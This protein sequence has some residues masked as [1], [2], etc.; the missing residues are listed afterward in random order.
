MKKLF[1][2]AFIIFASCTGNHTLDG[3]YVKG[4]GANNMSNE[5]L[6]VNGNEMT[7]AKYSYGGKLQGET[8]VTCTQFPDRI[9]FTENGIIKIMRIIDSGSLKLSDEAI[10]VRYG[11]F[12]DSFTIKEIKPNH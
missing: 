5:V 10:F 8:K 6:K 1:F 12:D 4:L 9:E 7:D 11:R 2:L 3:L